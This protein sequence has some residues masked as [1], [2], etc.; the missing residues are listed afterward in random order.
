MHSHI[1]L[2][3]F[4]LCLLLQTLAPSLHL[5]L[6]VS[7]HY[8][9][10]VSIVLSIKLNTLTFMFLAKT[11]THNFG[12]GSLILLQLP[13]QKYC[14]DKPRFFTINIYYLSS[15]FTLLIIYWNTV[16][17]ITFNTL[18]SKNDIAKTNI[19]LNKFK[20]FIYCHSFSLNI[21]KCLI[22]H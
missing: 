9:C 5:H 12:N 7:C 14:E 17:C 22:Y 4:H 16:Y 13:L 19:F 15:Y 18:L 2:S 11:E 1:H 8:V 3:L 10:L 21:W 20:H 6:Q